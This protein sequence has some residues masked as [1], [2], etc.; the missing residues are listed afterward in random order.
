MLR[1]IPLLIIGLL[2][3]VGIAVALIFLPVLIQNPI[4]SPLPHTEKQVIGFLPYWLLQRAATD[5]S[6][7]SN[8]LTYFALRINPDG[9]IQKFIAPKEAEPGYHALF[10]GKVDPFLKKAKA[11]HETLSLA[12]DSGDTKTI[13]ALVA[14]P[15]AHAKTLAS[16]VTPLLNKYGFTDLNLDIEYTASASASNRARFTTFLQD[17]KK[18][19]AG[20]ATITVEISTMDVLF[21][22]LIDVK[23]VS[24]IADTIVLMAYDY[25]S[26]DSYVTGP[27]APLS[28]AG[29]VSE[30]DVTTA[31]TKSLAQVPP[32]KL[33]LGIPLYGYEWES[34]GKVPRDAVIP[35]SGVTAS[36]R[37]MQDFL[38]TCATCS[39]VMDSAAVEPYV[40]Y[41]SQDT[42][43]Q[44]IIFY[45]DAQSTAAK[46]H[47]AERT[48]LAGVALWALG[49]EGPTIIKPLSSYLHRI[50][51]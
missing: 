8:T 32:D 48:H 42:N 7:Y 11:A 24:T 3:G 15:P 33:I 27:V 21:K 14:T 23:A 1:K 29:T 37:R 5:Y 47:L 50:N 38:A 35:G 10:S 22:N 26:T 34:L 18:D 9:S 46:L 19:L 40:S 13:E 17:V 25:H 43:T 28:G 4:I 44:H 31:V 30:Y 41:F 51:E 45:P 12:I 36:N 6:S 49:Y 16:Q 39:A 20:K 2:T